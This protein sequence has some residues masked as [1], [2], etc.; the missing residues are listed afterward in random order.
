MKL[1]LQFGYGMMTHVKN[2][3]KKWSEGTVILS[4]RDMSEDQMS[5][6]AQN[7]TE[8]NGKTLL[9]PQLYVPRSDHHGLLKHDYY[10]EFGGD[11]FSTNLIADINSMDD[12]Y[13]ELKRLNDLA[14]TDKYIIPG[15]LCESPDE[16]WLMLQKS[17]LKASNNF[18]KDKDKLATLCISS[19]ILNSTSP[20]KIEKLITYASK[21]DISGFYVLPEGDYLVNN[22][23]WFTNLLTLVSGL[24]LLNK[25]VIVGYSNHQML[26]LACTKIDAI[27]T[28]NWLNV[29][30]FN[31]KRFE[32]PNSTGGRKVAWYYCPCTQ[33]EYRYAT[34]EAVKRLKTIDMNL[35]KTDISMNSNYM[36]SYFNNGIEF[37]EPDTF[38]HYFQCLY[39]QCEI[40]SKSTYEE[41]FDTIV[42]LQ[43]NSEDMIE[44]FSKHSLRERDRSYA[45]VG[46][47]TNLALQI[48]NKEKGPLMRRKWS[49]I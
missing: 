32:E 18:F 39:K 44:N 6:L 9:D 38:K 11:N 16:A 36:D 22:S 47:A 34:L 20:E 35:L 45:T 13:T 33:S 8:Y 4:P 2:M 7:I 26:A 42:S 3:F 31:L 37:K 19:K 24:K 41:T 25:E 23:I 17:F 29:R 48:F 10:Q 14:Q 30:H 46:E 5:K 21:W 15:L 28:G 43:I 12:L 40:V 1:Y 49:N 27:A